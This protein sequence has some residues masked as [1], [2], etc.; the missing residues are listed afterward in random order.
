MI[1]K[2]SF[3][4]ISVILLSL[5]LFCSCL[6]PAEQGA[7]RN[8]SASSGTAISSEQTPPYNELELTHDAIALES[9]AAYYLPLGEGKYIPANDAVWKAYLDEQEFSAL[10][11]LSMPFVAVDLGE[12]AQVYVMENPL[13]TKVVF[14]CDPDLRLY[15][16]GEESALDPSAIN[17]VRVYTVSNSAVDVAAAYKSYLAETRPIVTLEEKAKQNP[18]VAK[19]YGAP[20]IYLWGD[21]L[22]SE[23]DIH[24]QAFL[25][26]LDSPVLTHISKVLEGTAEDDGSF[27]QVIARLHSQDYVDQYQKSVLLRGISTALKQEIFYDPAVLTKS[28]DAIEALLAKKQRN[29]VE[30]ME[31]NKQALYENLPNVFEPAAEWYN[32]ESV[33]ILSEMKAAGIDNAWIGLNSWE[34]AYQKPQLV[35]E[36]VKYGYLI[37]PYDSYHSI[38]EPGKEQWITAAFPDASLYENATVQNE[39]GEKIAGFQNVGRKLNPTLAMPAVQQRVEE[40][41]STGLQFNSWF[42]DCDATGEVY[43][44]YSSDHPTTKQQ[45]IA[46]RLKRLDYIAREH[47]MVVGSEGGNDYAANDIAFAHGIELQSFSWMDDDMKSN[48]GSEYYLGKYYNAKGGVPEKFAKLVPV[49][50]KYRQLFLDMSY[51]IPL[52]KMVYNNSMISAYHWDW[53]TFKIVDEAESRMLREILYN[54]PPM[55]HLDRAEWEKYRDRIIDHHAMW[56]AFSKKAITREITGFAF[57]SDDRLVQSTQYGSDLQVVANFTGD[58]FLHGDMMIPPR[59]ALLID[60]S[61]SNIIY[62]P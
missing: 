41:V 51:Q 61:G 38:H 31:L 56:S 40:I 22:L 45:D 16:V 62:T 35:Q 30:R 49:K 60:N 42:V 37:G 19:L 6:K 7:S 1:R 27:S 2:N 15:I 3:L 14:T 46:A 4:S 12:Q 32:Q 13:R 26:A 11:S 39:K 24:W 58:D 23:G 28:N 57:L 17:T 20:H 8:P 33:D 53:S 25:R 48:K 44:D 43:D 10:E 50:E 47:G 18:N 9:G 55:Y 21:F 52:Y 36:A 5:V 34:Q 54:V 59:S 29:P